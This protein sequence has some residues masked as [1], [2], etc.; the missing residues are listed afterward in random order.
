MPMQATTTTPLFS[1]NLTPHRSLNQRQ[2]ALLSG[3]LA[4]AIVGPAFVY[5]ALGIVAAVGFV[6]LILIGIGGVLYFSLRQGRRSEQVTLWPDELE[7][8]FTDASGT[9][10]LRRLAPRGVRLTL[11]RDYDEKTTALRLKA[12][13]EEIELGAFLH[14]DDKASFAKAFGTA[15]RRARS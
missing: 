4:V 12:G 8:T 14:T 7:I 2:L 5:I 13:P 6:L 10:T 9:R 15:L 11:D 1:A 3:L